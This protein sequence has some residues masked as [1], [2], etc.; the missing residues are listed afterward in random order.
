M[1]DKQ[2]WKLYSELVEIYWKRGPRGL[3]AD[4]VRVQGV[5][6]YYIS[7]KKAYEKRAQTAGQGPRRQRRRRVKT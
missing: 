2:G 3:Y 4:R 5:T 1:S 6:F 7:G